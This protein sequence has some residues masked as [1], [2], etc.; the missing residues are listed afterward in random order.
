ME[1]PKKCNPAK[2]GGAGGAVY[3]LG[4]VGA[5]VY[6]IQ[7]A[8]TF[9]LGVLG[10]LKAIVWPAMIIYHLLQFLNM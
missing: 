2:C 6:Y 3:G 9:W 1:K 8:E 5:V 7:H 4:L 10:I